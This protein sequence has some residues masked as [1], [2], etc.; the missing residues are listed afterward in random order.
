[1]KGTNTGILKNAETS[2][3][4]T[5][6]L[7]S[8]SVETAKKRQMLQE[9]RATFLIMKKKIEKVHGKASGQA[10]E[11]V[12]HRQQAG[13]RIQASSHSGAVTASEPGARW[14]AVWPRCCWV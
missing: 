9:F 8:L 14:S 12:G 10:S 3:L 5:P 4:R 13:S 11:G 2:A 6:T 7:G 1:M